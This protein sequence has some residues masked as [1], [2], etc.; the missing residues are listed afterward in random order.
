MG[1][2]AW[3]SAKNSVVSEVTELV[4]S[5]MKELRVEDERKN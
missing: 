1:F 4:L 2:S 5:G 3:F